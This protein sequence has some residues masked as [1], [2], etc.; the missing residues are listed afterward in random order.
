MVSKDSRF[1][2]QNPAEH[3][4]FYTWL[5]GFL[6]CLLRA[7]LPRLQPQERAVGPPFSLDS[8]CF[9]NPTG[10]FYI[11]CSAPGRRGNWLWH[12]GTAHVMPRF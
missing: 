5:R 10:D 11:V 2:F 3:Q 6:C 4:N 7:Q 12:H 9:E 8:Q 1:W